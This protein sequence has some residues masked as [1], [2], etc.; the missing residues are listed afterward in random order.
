MGGFVPF[1]HTDFHTARFYRSLLTL[2][3]V[4]LKYSMI[5]GYNIVQFLYEKKE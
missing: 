3:L 5:I 1:H 2:F 4:S